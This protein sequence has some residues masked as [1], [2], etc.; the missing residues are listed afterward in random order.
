MSPARGVDTAERAEAAP[1]IND[2]ERVVKEGSP[3]RDKDFG[4]ETA[5]AEAFIPVKCGGSQPLA[6]ESAGHRPQAI[7]ESTSGCGISFMCVSKYFR[8]SMTFAVTSS[9]KR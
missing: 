3:I 9:P 8:P 5:G 1:A 4:N 6:R 2:V 7:D